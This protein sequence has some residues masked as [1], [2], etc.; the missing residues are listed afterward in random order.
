MEYYN[1]EV[2]T[3]Y[4]ESLRAKGTQEQISA[5]FSA[6][7]SEEE[8]AGAD[9]GAMSAEQALGIYQGTN[10]INLASIRTQLASINAYRHWYWERYGV[11]YPNDPVNLTPDRVNIST[12]MENVFVASWTD[13]MD[14]LHQ[15]NYDFDQGYETAPVLA[16]NWLGFKTSEAVLLKEEQVD[17]KRRVICDERGK[18]L[19]NGW[20]PEILGVL[21]AYKNTPKANRKRRHDEQVYMVRTGYFIHRMDT[22]NSKKPIDKPQSVNTVARLIKNAAAEYKGKTGKESKMNSIN[23][24]YSGQYHRL[25]EYLRDKTV[26]EALYDLDV[27]FEMKR[28]MGNM[29]MSAKDILFMHKKYEVAFVHYYGSNDPPM[30]NVYE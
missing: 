12:S 26:E 10:P 19:V 6:F 23:V 1:N 4:L 15:I 7:K 2:K 8:K 9:L 30:A 20:E 27:Q 24:R 11:Q 17:L 5:V 25:H 28:I 3:E 14:E 16:L 21:Q 18:V 13:I 22:R 29:E